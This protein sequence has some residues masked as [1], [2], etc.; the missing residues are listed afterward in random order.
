MPFKLKD[1]AETEGLPTITLAGSAYFV[2]RLPLRNRIK[3]AGLVPKVLLIQEHLLAALGLAAGATPDEIKQAIAAKP[4]VK[5]DIPEDSYVAMVDVVSQGLLPLY[6]GATRDELLDQPIDFED[7]HAAWP[8][9]V[10][11]GASRRP[12]E[13]EA[14]ATSS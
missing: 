4:G 14:L 1:G 13:G 5:V 12:P 8:I 6:P 2:A 9:V 10:D 3:I 11:Q 7:L